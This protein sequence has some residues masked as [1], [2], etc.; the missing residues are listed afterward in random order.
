MSHKLF[1]CIDATRWRQVL[2]CIERDC[3]FEQEADDEPMI[4][5][6]VAIETLHNLEAHIRLANRPPEMLS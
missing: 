4:K 6:L 2:R 3:D 5:E 1:I